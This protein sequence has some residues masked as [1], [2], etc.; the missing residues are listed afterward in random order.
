M[1]FC[2]LISEDE[3]EQNII[4]QVLESHDCLPVFPKQDDFELLVDFCHK[5]LSPVFHGVADLHFRTQEPFNTASWLIYQLMN[6][7]WAD[8]ALGFYNGDADL[9]WVHDFHLLLVPQFVARKYKRANIGFFLHVPFPPSEQ[10]RT[11]PVR[12]EVSVILAVFCLQIL[13]AMLCA[14]LLGFHFFEYAR[15]FFIATKRLL[16]LDH[17]FTL[18]GFLGIEYGGRNVMVK[19]CHVNVEYNDLRS[20]ICARQDIIELAMQLRL[21][22]QNKFI[23]GAVDRFD[24]L[25]G[26]VLKFHSFG[27]FLK[28]FPY[29]RERVV[30]I[31]VRHI[32]GSETFFRKYAYPTRMSAKE[33]EKMTNE[34]TMMANKIN[35]EFGFSIDLKIQRVLPEDKYAILQAAD[36]LLDTSIRDGLNLVRLR[37][38]WSI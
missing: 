30:L 24:Q 10:F 31:Q 12:E 36:C 23:F 34:L 8:T 1:G 14:D 28:Q 33:T 26:L 11:L 17:H 18:G 13:R 6:K 19:I 20:T 7:L 4:R 3:D 5:Y 22:H 9:V 2:G 37:C 38:R 32:Y 16:G 35:S 29:A 21:K 25:A 27:F 15:H